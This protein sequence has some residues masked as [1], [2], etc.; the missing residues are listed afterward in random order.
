MQELA[1][2]HDVSFNLERSSNG[3]ERK[4]ERLIALILMLFQISAPLPFLGPELWPSPPAN[5]VL[6]S[7]DT[8]IPRT[9]ELALRRAI[10]ANTNMKAIQNSLEDISY[11]LRIPQRKPYGT[12][13]GNV[14]KALKANRERNC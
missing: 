7:P 12:M 8:K 2:Q 5:A 4:L 10:P 1:D 3:H 14:K 11:L 6:Y 13:E 9:G